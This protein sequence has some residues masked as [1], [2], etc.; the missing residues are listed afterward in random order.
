MEKDKEKAYDN[1]NNHGYKLLMS[2]EVNYFN[3]CKVNSVWST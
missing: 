3:E 1:A 2:L